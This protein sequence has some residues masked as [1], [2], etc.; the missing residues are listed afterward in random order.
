V[1][2][3]EQKP[4]KRE[5]L[6]AYERSRYT[7]SVD[8]RLTYRNGDIALLILTVKPDSRAGMCPA[9]TRPGSAE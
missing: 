6:K 8:I 7:G 3:A 4:T 9:V 5:W 1:V 2:Q